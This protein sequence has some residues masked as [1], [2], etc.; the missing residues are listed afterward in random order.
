MLPRDCNLWG[1]DFSTL[2]PLSPFRVQLI[3]KK[4]GR[5]GMRS[6][7]W[8]GSTVAIRSA[9]R[10]T[11][12]LAQRV[13]PSRAGIASLISMAAVVVCAAAP[14]QAQQVIATIT[15]TVSGTDRT[16]V[17]GFAPGTAFTNQPFNLVYTIT[18]SNGQ[19]GVVYS[20]GTPYE[21]YIEN[22][23]L[24]N[25]I[26]ATLTINN[27]SFTFGT[28]PVS[29]VASYVERF[30]NLTTGEADQIYFYLQE[31]LAPPTGGDAIANSF[32]AANG[33][34]ESDYKWD[35]PV[36]Y[37]GPFT[38]AV[39][40]FNIDYTDESAYGYMISNSIMIGGPVLTAETGKNLGGPC[41]PRTPDNLQSSP[42]NPRAGGTSTC[43]CNQPTAT[44]G[45]P[46][47]AATGNMF[48]VETD[49]AGASCTGLALRRYYNSQDTIGAAF[50]IG[51]RS[52]WQRSL[53]RVSPNTVVIT[54]ADGREDTF[55]L[56]AGVWQA[57][58]DVT[59]VLTPVPAT[60][61]QTGWQL[62]TATDATETYSL[63]GQL[64][65]VTTRAG[66]TTT[67]AYNSSGQL[68][69][70]TGPFGDILKFT[71]NATGQITQ[72]TAPDGGV[73]SY[74]YDANSNLISVTHPDGSVRQYVYGDASFP[75]ALTGIV[76]EDGN[77]YASWAYD[78][79]GR[80]I[81][82]QHAGG[83]DL[84]TVAYNADGGASATDADGN[85]HSYTF[86][87]Q[88]DAVKP[89]AL[90]GAPYP[91]AGGQ[92]FGYDSNGFVASRTD[93]DGN[94][95]AYTH[96]RRGDE[97]SRTEASGSAIARTIST[98][99][100]A[101]FH[102]PTSITEPGR[103]TSFAYDARGN[104]LQKTITAGSLKRSWAYTYN[105]NGQVLTATDPLGHV[106]SY[107]YDTAGDVTSI[108][109]ALGHVTALTGYDADGRLL[110]MTDPNGLVTTLTYNFR[111]EVTS[112]NIG[113]EV[114]S[115]A[116]DPAGQLIKTTLPDG[117]F[118]AFTYDAA[119]RLTGIKDAAGDSVA[120]ALDPASNVTKTQ[121]LNP[122]G[123]LTQ[124][125]SYAYD[126]VNRVAQAI[127]AQGQTTAY[128]YD[129]NSNLTAV[130]DPL[131][132]VNAY[133]YDALNRLT[134]NVDPE[135]GATAFGYD[136]LDHLTAVTDPRSLM[137]G[138]TWDTLDDQTAVASPDS[139]TTARTFDAAGNVLTSTDARGDK[140]TYSYDALNRPIKAAYAGGGSVTWQYDQGTYGIGHLTTMT[141]L[142]GSTGW[143]YDQHG[144]VLSKKQTSGG[145]TFTTAMTYDAAGRLATI[146]YPSG[147]VITLAY[148]AA[149]R[150]SSLKSGTAPLV[151]GVSYFP[152][153]PAESWTQGNGGDYSRAFDQDGRIDSIG[154]G[155]DT[156]ALAYDAASRI[157]GIT[158]TG[159]AAKSFG[160]DALDRLTGY[161]S[162]ST[163]L[164][165]GYDANGNRTSLGGS[166]SIA[167]TIAGASNRV[168]DAGPR[169]FT[170]DADGHL[171]ADNQATTILGYT[172]DASGRLVTAKTGAETTN[173]TNDGLG[174][175]VTRGGYGASSYA[176]SKQEFVYDPAG[177]L[178]GEYDGN[179]KAIEETVWLGDLPV[180]VLAP[181]S[182]TYYAAPD[183][184]GA[185]HQL[186]N[187]GGTTAWHWDHDPFG[188][189]APTG[190]YAYNLRFPGQYFDGETGLHYNGLRDYDP[191]TGRYVQSDPIGLGGGVNTY[192][193]VSGNPLSRTDR[194]GL[195]DFWD[196]PATYSG[197]NYGDPYCDTNPEYC[198]DVT[199]PGGTIPPISVS[200][201]AGAMGN[202]GPY[203]GGGDSG[204]AFDT[205]GHLCVYENSCQSIVESYGEGGSIG[206]SG[207]LSSGAL[208]T[209]SQTSQ[210]IYYYGGE[211]IGGEGQY[212]VGPNG[213]IGYARGILGPSEGAGGGY[214][215]CHTEYQCTGG[216]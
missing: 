70:V 111:G 121:I 160:Y 8:G 91:P 203:G 61:T 171:T 52:A 118:F 79:Q 44:V 154:F 13:R 167:Y 162:G 51:W 132:H 169:T 31:N 166:S 195:E 35:S 86:Q 7:L 95:T 129:P 120:Y 178:L 142:S 87:T 4:R 146:T 50:G 180:A 134:G 98:A 73:F 125:R 45:E 137:T 130:S 209:G 113:G 80:A 200:V 97:T 103:V 177:H 210:G 202:I 114:T 165:Y 153:G 183:Q 28:R 27:N 29:E 133:S 190:S 38:E 74:A 5:S 59:S 24:N 96:D 105:A 58:P 188:N 106:T 9:F 205:Q 72:M 19:Q 119:H 136:A 145:L 150:V 124:T 49:F 123:S 213:N 155:G 77:A 43:G 157:T 100:L 30:V 37:S 163:G 62:V 216:Q 104:L 41:P 107:T 66:L 92:A 152:F 48:L 182:L 140:T 159:Y 36:S 67:L 198:E 201:G 63:S 143:T 3:E 151:S 168:L 2:T 18:V 131:S 194:R 187:A 93:Y 99:W 144:R 215:V 12:R 46:I 54:R 65:A 71:S 81:S 149:D 102:L 138:Y 164:T 212:T 20:N 108:K 88:F 172:Y 208:C 214:I 69:S 94:V 40:S 25:P 84:T 42:A 189:G 139:G 207:Q 22:S 17:F 128:A 60:G 53:T 147:A 55:T 170:Y 6:T 47:N 68:S 23:G 175:R 116:Y 110:S 14:A 57:D 196:N 21:S 1:N 135:G 185:P 112:R 16:G 32:D 174:E 101:T 109:D 158:E 156:L 85:T 75:N 56:N 39:T 211:G 11:V 64:T 148:D 117:S 90:S 206:I 193:Y 197:G 26:T 10:Q 126:D 83:A 15:G 127:G 176:G 192:A 184:L 173:Y 89:A 179:G 82:S 181:G 76:D 186:A 199:F 33:N 122:G 204:V 161:T 78:A 141:D 34:L 115:Y 191:S